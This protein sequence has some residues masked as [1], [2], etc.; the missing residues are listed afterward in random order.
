MQCEECPNSVQKRI[1]FGGTP[2]RFCSSTCQARAARRRYRKA[3]LCSRCLKSCEN[4]ICESCRT[5]R[6]LKGRARYK[7]V[8]PWRIVDS[9]CGD[10]GKYPRVVIGKRKRWLSFYCIRCL[11]GQRRRRVRSVQ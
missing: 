10:C 9:L 2:K 7:V 4:G 11:R 8:W 3:G 1:A 5:K 6:N